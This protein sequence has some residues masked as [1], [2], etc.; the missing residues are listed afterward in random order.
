MTAQCMTILPRW[1]PVTWASQAA[2]LATR[3]NIRICN[4]RF[5]LNKVK[6]SCYVQKLAMKQWFNPTFACSFLG[7]NSKQLVNFDQLDQE[8]EISVVKQSS[9]SFCHVTTCV[10]ILRWKLL[11]RVLMIWKM[12]LSWD[13]NMLIVNSHKYFDDCTDCSFLNF[14]LIALI[15]LLIDLFTTLVDWLMHLLYCCIE[16]IRI[17]VNLIWLNLNC[18]C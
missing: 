8:V 5:A 18:I 13:F 6:M 2:W 14:A 4:W 15:A 12:L 7:F 3:T 10:R 1:R 16:K 11:N 17:W 9:S